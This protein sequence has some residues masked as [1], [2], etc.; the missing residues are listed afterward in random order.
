M[1]YKSIKQIADEIGISKQRVYRY[2]KQ[3]HII[4]AHQ[5]NGTLYYDEAA[6]NLIIQGFSE[7]NASSEV[8]QKRTN[9]TA[10]ETVIKML[11][12]ELEAKDRQIEE[13]Q[14]ALKR[15]QELHTTAQLLHSQEQHLHAATLKQLPA[16][17]LEASEGALDAE[18]APERKKKGW[19]FPWKK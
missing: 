4:E 15:E 13:L 12:N 11:Q 5:E 3:H 19:L 17:E 14:A 8:D 7:K 1:A 10:F 9:D 18:P 16:P 6:E 2:I